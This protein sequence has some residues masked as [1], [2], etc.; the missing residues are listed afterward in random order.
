[1]TELKTLM[2]GSGI[3]EEAVKI[4]HAGIDALL[5]DVASGPFCLQRQ[6]RLLS[7]RAVIG[8]QDR[9]PGLKET[10]LGVN[11]LLVVFDPFQIHPSRA[12]S[13]LLEL[14]MQVRPKDMKGRRIS[15]EVCYGGDFGLDLDYISQVSGLSKTSV[16]DLHCSANYTVAAIGSM[17]GFAYLVGLPK[18][19]EVPRRQSPRTKLEK[20]SVIIAGEQASILPFTGPCGWHVIGHAEVECFDSRIVPPVLFSPGDQI[21]FVPKAVLK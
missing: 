7:L 5:I 10:V 16:I 20:G 19:L 1:M 8:S 14:W 17:P 13:T 15:I 11:N 4:S 6:Q 12:R 3:A 18:E 21:V 9:F 2:N